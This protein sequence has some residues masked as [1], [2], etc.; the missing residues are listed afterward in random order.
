MKRSTAG[1]STPFFNVISAIEN[2]G[3]EKSTG[4]ARSLTGSAP[5]P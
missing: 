5:H 3:I 2:R 1:L 4:N